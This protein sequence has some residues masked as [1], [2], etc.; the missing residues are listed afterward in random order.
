M[1]IMI[2]ASGGADS[3]LLMY[4]T[5]EN[6]DHEAVAFHFPKESFLRPHEPVQADRARD[7][8]YAVTNWLKENTRP[9]DI[10]EGAV[11]HRKSTGEQFDQFENLPIRPGHSLEIAAY[12]MRCFY[13]TIGFHTDLIAPDQ[14][15][16]AHTTVNTIRGSN[17]PAIMGKGPPENYADYTSVPFVLPWLTRRSDGTYEGRGRNEVLARLPTGLEDILLKCMVTD[18]PC[19]ECKLCIGW[20]FFDQIARGRPL[21][22]I[23][24]IDG[25]IEELGAVGRFMG[26]SDP[27]TYSP[28]TRFDILE[29]LAPWR[30]WLAATFPTGG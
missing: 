4:E 3:A 20:T 22:Q 19:G 12:W 28:N 25:R 7:A 26:L 11:V 30:A 6:T 2:P 5:L 27:E 16:L 8:F 23:E 21:E 18:P 10:R 15:W 14:M 1:K 24:A 13:A 17:W 29:D 9:F